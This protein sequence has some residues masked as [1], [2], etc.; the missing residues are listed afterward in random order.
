[1]KTQKKF[2]SGNV[3]I[4][5]VA[6][7]LHDIYSCFLAPILPLL[8]DKLSITLSGAGLLSVLGRLPSLGNPFLGLLAD[9]IHMRYL[10]I[11]APALTA[12]AMSFLGVAPTYG[13]LALLLFAMGISSALFHVSCPVMVKHIS[14][15]R[16]GK[17]M[18]FY[19]FGGEIARALGPLIILGGISL[20]GLEG[21]WRLLFFGVG[22][23]LILYFKLRHI[24]ISQDFKTQKKEKGAWQTFLMHLPLFSLLSG[25]IFFRAVMHSSLTVFLPTY[26]KFEGATLWFGGISLSLLQFSGAL[27]TFFSGSLSDRIGRKTTLLIGALST[28]LLMWFFI[29]VKGILRI[30]FLILIGITLFSQSPILLALI[31]DID[32]ERPA[33]INGIYMAISFSLSALATVIVGIL[34]DW[35]GLEATYKLAA[36]SACIA[37]PFV[38]ALRK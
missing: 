2:Q 21:S 13:I 25:F 29:S 1:M 20:W 16:I 17:G 12:I 4:L 3:L 33:F 22:L 14:G 31:H 36:V 23:S 32:H 6:H 19:M 34:G 8:I 27:S 30:P 28:P 15:K 9:K 26:L 11:I 35:I 38:L 7:T 37:I 10:I 5:S 24:N 18:S